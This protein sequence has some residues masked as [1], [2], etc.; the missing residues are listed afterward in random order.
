[1]GHHHRP[2]ARENDG[3]V[4]FQVRYRHGGAD[5]TLE[6]RARDADDARDRLIAKYFKW[7]HA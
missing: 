1:M 5:W 4:P 7:R 2:P 6:L 3:L